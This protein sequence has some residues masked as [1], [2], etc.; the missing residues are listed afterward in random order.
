MTEKL[1]L[2]DCDGVLLDWTSMF[3]EY[4]ETHGFTIKPGPKYSYILDSH[5]EAITYDEVKIH[6]RQFNESAAIGFLQPFRD[7]I[8]YVKRLYEEHGYRFRVI[9]SLSS[10]VYAAKLREHNLRQYFGDAIES[11]SCL[12]CGADKDEAL[13]EF[14]HSQLFWIEDKAQNADVGHQLGLSSILMIHD[15]NK[16]HKCSYPKVNI[17]KEIYERIT[18]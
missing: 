12:E 11:V 3:Y 9:T 17:W 10:N 4:M 6:I 16:D 8:Y 18:K 5:F 7:S 2:T 1:I 13:K 15:H 14:Q